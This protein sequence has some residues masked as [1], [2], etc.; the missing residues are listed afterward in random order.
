MILKPNGIPLDRVRAHLTALN[1][2]E[3]IPPIVPAALGDESGLR[4]A[5]A[6]LTQG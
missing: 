2:A 3:K 6:I 5:L 1:K 4:G